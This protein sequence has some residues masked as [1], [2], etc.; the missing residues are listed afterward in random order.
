MGQRMSERKRRILLVDD[1]ESIL[2]TV[3]FALRERGYE[4]ITARDGVEGLMRIERDTPDLVILDLI[5]PRRSGLSVLERLHGSRR[6]RPRIIMV[7]AIDDPRQRD[8][9]L[10]RGAERYLV[11]PYD[12]DELMKSVDELLNGADSSSSAPLES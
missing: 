10:S 3:C 1:D 6:H 4:V 9:A 2:E 7:S 5:M 11:K 8:F 12:L